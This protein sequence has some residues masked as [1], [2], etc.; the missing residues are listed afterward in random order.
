VVF[1][2]TNPNWN[3][4]PEYQANGPAGGVIDAM[5]AQLG[6]NPNKGNIQAAMDKLEAASH[7]LAESGQPLPAIKQVVTLPQNAVPGQQCR[8][9]NPQTPGTYMNVQVPQNAQPGQ[10]IM[11][12][13]PVQPNQQGNGKKGMSTGAKVGF[14]LGG[15]ALVGGCA[16]AGAMAGEAGAFDG[17]IDAAPDVLDGA[18][19]AAMDVGDFAGDAFGDAGDFLT[20]LF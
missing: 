12:Q 11:T 9:A 3:S 20:D 8:V 13:A 4:M 10:P 15:A 7:A 1:E 16:Y 19:D 6:N 18:G 5:M 2:H 14:A 17:A